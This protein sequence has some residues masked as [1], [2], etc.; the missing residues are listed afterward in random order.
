MDEEQELQS[1]IH[2]LQGKKVFHIAKSMT[3]RKTHQDALPLRH[4]T[5]LV[6]VPVIL[7][8]VLHHTMCLEAEVGV[9][10][11]DIQRV[12]V[13]VDPELAAEGHKA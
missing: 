1:R 2:A 6:H 10:D 13:E 4:R 7:N 9:V 12:L 5:D 8:I 11:M 3:L